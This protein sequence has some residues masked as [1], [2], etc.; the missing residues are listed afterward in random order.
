[1]LEA[2]GFVAKSRKGVSLESEWRHKL[3]PQNKIILKLQ[4]LLALFATPCVVGVGVRC[5]SS[6]ESWFPEL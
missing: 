4:N 2:E 6:P 5:F 3:F 1:M